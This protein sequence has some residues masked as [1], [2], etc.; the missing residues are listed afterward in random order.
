MRM[1]CVSLCV[2]LC[3]CL[4]VYVCV[5]TVNDSGC[6]IQGGGGRGGLLVIQ[7]VSEQE[8]PVFGSLRRLTRVC[9][10]MC[11]GMCRI[12]TAA[13]FQLCAV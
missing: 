6:V 1:S 2:R 13:P 7:G 8:R 12:L 9:S 5:L 11:S 3:G 10:G 4:L